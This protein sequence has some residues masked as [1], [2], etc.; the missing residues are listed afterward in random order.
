[1]QK[2]FFFLIWYTQ[3]CKKSWRGNNDMNSTDNELRT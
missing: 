2:E 3:A 1:M